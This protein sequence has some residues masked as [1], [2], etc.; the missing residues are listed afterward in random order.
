MSRLGEVRKTGTSHTYRRPQHLPT[1]FSV[2][3]R[4]HVTKTSRPSRNQMVL[5]QACPYDSQFRK[6]SWL[7]QFCLLKPIPSNSNNGLNESAILAGVGWNVV[8]AGGRE[9]KMST[10]E[11]L[12]G[13]GSTCGLQC[14]TSPTS[15]KL[16]PQETTNQ[17]FP[18]YRARWGWF[19]L[20][21]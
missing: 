6:A 19:T 18:D 17:D 21:W 7:S 3:S 9:H 14:S 16:T 11:S 2:R 8:E 10:A 13:L 5:G 12:I 4:T 1:C 15:D 20:S